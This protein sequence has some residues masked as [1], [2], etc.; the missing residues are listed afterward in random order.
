MKFNPMKFFKYQATGNDF[1]IID[2]SLK[3]IK[4]KKN[5]IERLC[6]RKFGIGAD[7]LILLENKVGCDYS[8][9]YYNS[10]GH[11]SSF[12]GNGSRCLAHFAHKNKIFEKKAIFFANDKYYQV[13][14]DNDIFSVKMQNISNVIINKDNSIFLD[15]GSPHLVFF[16]DSIQ[17]LDLGYLG[18]EIRNLPAYKE[19]GV[20]VNF[21]EV[22]SQYLFVRTYERGV[23]NETLSCGTG[24][25][26]SAIAAHHKSFINVNNIKIKTNG[27]V[28]NVSFNFINNIYQDIY[29]SGD[30]CLVFQGDI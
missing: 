11:Q 13:H 21:V 8:M 20:N 3:N 7:G 29:L 4:L 18:R 16:K 26:A 5:Q 27:G 2:N 12:C 17:D 9:I 15:T 23:E 30:A 24:V 19:K 22:S 6:S 10:D 28:L 14:R 25:V 1:I